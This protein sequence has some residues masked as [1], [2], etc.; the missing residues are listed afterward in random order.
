VIIIRLV[1]RSMRSHAVSTRDIGSRR[2]FLGL[3]LPSAIWVPGTGEVPA[4]ETMVQRR[5]S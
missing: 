4:Q 1:A 2:R 5:A 3:L